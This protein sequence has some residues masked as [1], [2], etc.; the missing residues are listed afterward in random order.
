MATDHRVLF[1]SL[2]FVAVGLVLLST[3]A[4]QAADWPRWR[5][6]NQDGITPGNDVFNAEPFALEMLWGRP[7]GIAYSGMSVVDGRVVTM[8]ADGETDFL[9]AIDGASGN[10][11]W[12]YRIAEMFPSRG[13]SEGGPVSVPAIDH[14]TVYGL[15]AQ[16]QLFAV[17]LKDGSEIW[18]ANIVETLGAIS[19]HF[20]FTSPPLIIDELL[21]LTAG[22]SDGRA[23]AGM[24]K[25]TGEIL[26]TAGDGTVEYQ[27]PLSATLAGRQQIVAV[28]NETVFGLDPATGEIL[29][30]HEHGTSQRGGSQFPVLIG[31]DRFL[32]TGRS[33]SAAFKVTATDEGFEVDEAWRTD[34]LKGSFATPVLYEGNIYG[35]SGDFLTCVSPEDGAKV[36]KSRPPG[37]QGLIVVDGHLVIYGAEGSLVVARATPDGYDEKARVQ[38]S[39]RGSYT[40]PSFADGTIYVRNTREIAGVKIS[41]DVPRASAEPT[42]PSNDFERFLRR[43]EGADNKRL[44]T[45]AFMNAQERFPIVEDNRLVHFVYRGNAEDVA[46]TGNMTA[47]RVEEPMQH[48]EG[49]DLYYRSYPIEPGARWEYRLN[50]DFENPQPDPLNPRR[51]PG[52]TGDMSELITAGW[53]QPDFLQPYEGDNPG[54]VESFEL[55]SKTLENSR[56]IHVYLPPGYDKG[57][58]RYPVLLFND[59]DPW[60]NWANLPNSLNQL[61]GTQIAPIIAV[62]V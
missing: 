19:P 59:G 22:G 31:D 24:N 9:V 45:D 34:N 14:G 50:V 57:S 41:Y 3:L 16:G 15:G 2:Q 52:R 20:G 18:S 55:T 39:E 4:A 54:R 43:V 62:F 5:G 49:T 8:F 23:F 32:L 13:G 53:S 47:L 17:N 48:V 10:E 11:I 1:R 40:Y 46:I 58:E 21:F 30:S 51:V 61:I 25:K 28:T 42:A 12:R 6:P 37:G 7:L 38:V 35:F 44:L 60:L 26:W 29:W 36:W 27:S 33:E 56:Q